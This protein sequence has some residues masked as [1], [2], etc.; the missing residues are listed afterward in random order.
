MVPKYVKNATLMPPRFLWFTR[1]PLAA[2][3]RGASSI[4]FE[5]MA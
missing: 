3:E 4:T 5:A 1:P 2:M